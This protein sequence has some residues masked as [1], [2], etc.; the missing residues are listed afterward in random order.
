MRSFT[1]FL[2]GFILGGLVGAAAAILLA[3]YSG[4]NLRGQMKSEAEHIQIEVKQAAADRRAELENQ[5]A[6]LRKPKQA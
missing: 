1:R 2:S 3:P 4:E 5:L 6:G